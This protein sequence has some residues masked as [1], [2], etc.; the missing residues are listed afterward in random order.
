MTP[1]P[2]FG[3]KAKSARKTARLGADALPDGLWAKCLT[4]G[5]ILF[6]KELEKNLRVCNK[7]GYHYKLSAADRIA[8]TADDAT[9]VEI[10]ADLRSTDPLGFPDYEKQL[11]KFQERSKL[12]DAI[13][14]GTCEIGGIPAMIGVLDFTFWGG[15]MGGVVGEKVVRAMEKAIEAKLPVVMVIASGGIR[16]NEGLSGL[17]QMAKTSAA[18]ARLHQAKIPYIVVL[19]DPSMAGVLASYGSLGDFIISEPGLLTG[20]T[21]DRVAQQAQVIH[22]PDNFRKAEFAL[23]HGQIDRIVTRRE[24]KS[25]IIKLLQF[26]GGEENQNAA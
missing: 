1:A 14:T 4:C 13:V 22:V 26:S 9:F 8:I 10:D 5:E 17:M 23:E 19:T 3:R 18:C 2:W 21:A 24:L 16:V 12:P 7:C 15:S 25:T 6:N 11:A 20:L